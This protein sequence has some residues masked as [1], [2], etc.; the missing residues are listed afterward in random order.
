MLARTLIR[1]KMS[2]T[3]AVV[4]SLAF[5]CDRKMRGSAGSRRSRAQSIRRGRD[6]PRQLSVNGCSTTPMFMVLNHQTIFVGIQLPF[7]FEPFN[8]ADSSKWGEFTN[9][10][11]TCEV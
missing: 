10:I 4:S 3:W 1:E 5:D 9:C 6:V 8:M 11:I 7:F 2:T